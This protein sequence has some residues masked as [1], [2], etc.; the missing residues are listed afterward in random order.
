MTNFS[1]VLSLP[2]V[3]PRTI[4]PAGSQSLKSTCYRI[5]AGLNSVK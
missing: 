5:K 3:R 4:E 1:R 2:A